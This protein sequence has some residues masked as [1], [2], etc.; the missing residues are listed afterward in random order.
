MTGIAGKREFFQ[1][2]IV[3]CIEK[4]IKDHLDRIRDDGLRKINV[5]QIDE[6][7]ESHH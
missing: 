5:L 6:E 4:K 2:V 1:E 7:Q 3:M